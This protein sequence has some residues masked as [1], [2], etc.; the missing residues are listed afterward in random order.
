MKANACVIGFL[1]LS[2]IF[3]VGCDGDGDGGQIV[4]DTSTDADAAATQDGDDVAKPE[5]VLASGTA[6]SHGGMGQRLCTV[7]PPE[8]GTLRGTLMWDP[9]PDELRIKFLFSDTGEEFGLT[10]G[11]NPLVT[12]VHVSEAWKT[13][14]FCIY[15]ESGA[16]EYVSYVVMFR[17]D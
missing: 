2:L 10:A 9:P 12:E 17:P 16:D 14:L 11:T 3:L 5:S 15:Q 13:W 4:Q 1:V 7:Y 8:P 6:T